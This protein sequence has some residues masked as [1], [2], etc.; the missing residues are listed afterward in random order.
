MGI[1]ISGY[2]QASMT[3]TWVDR[4]RVQPDGA[5]MEWTPWGWLPATHWRIRFLQQV[6]R[7][8]PGGAWITI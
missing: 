8:L 1:S 2:S 4:R 5:P 7:G 3:L 6:E